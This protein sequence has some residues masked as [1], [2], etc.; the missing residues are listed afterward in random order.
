MFPCVC[1]GMTFI[2]RPLADGL[3]VHKDVPVVRGRRFD[4]AQ[5]S[6]NHSV[7]TPRG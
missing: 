7:Q 3:F 1:L 2:P 4:L 6:A 5:P